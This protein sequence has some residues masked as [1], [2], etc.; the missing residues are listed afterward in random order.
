M[1]RDY[2]WWAR[3]P[4]AGVTDADVGSGELLGHIARAHKYEYVLRTPVVARP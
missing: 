1:I 4:A 3:C 2:G